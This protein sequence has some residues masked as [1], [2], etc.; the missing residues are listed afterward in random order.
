MSNINVKGIQDYLKQNQ[1]DGWLIF[2]FRGQNYVATNFFKMNKERLL[3]R[4]WFYFIPQVGQPQLVI[5]KIERD[6]FPNPPQQ[7]Q[8]YVSWQ[9]LGNH[10]R[11]MM[12]GCKKIA[13]EYSPNGAIPYVS[14]VDG[15][16]LEFVRALGF[17]IVTSANLV[18]YFQCRWTPEQLQSHIRAV[19]LL[20]QIKD[21]AFALIG[22]RLTNQQTVNEYDVQRFILNSLQ[23]N[24]LLTDELPIVSVNANAS[25]P[26]YAPSSN[27]FSP[28]KE[29]D[30]VLIDLF[31]KE[32]TANAVYGDITWVGFAG[33]GVPEKYSEIFKIVAAARDAGLESLKLA[34]ARGEKI[35]GWQVDRCVRD[36]IKKA[37]YG[38][39]F[40]HRTGHSLHTKI[41]GNGVNID[42]LET[43]DEREIIPGLGF[44]I[45]PGIYLEEFGVRSEVDVYYDEDGPKVYAPI[46]QEVVAILK[47]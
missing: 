13:M 19:K 45:E 11:E 6:N 3:T 7:V 34:A 40:D 20:D 21:E 37:G 33:E 29:N 26:H 41:H 46:Q 32:R 24:D 2:D 44:T 8:Y 25:N 30:F 23:D 27:R 15:G 31:A 14:T 1:I 28:I 43:Q 47:S 10:L 22:R 42:S 4:R 18:Q 39:Y 38:D 36:Y 12:Q 35:Q 9:E 5:H 16:T 17:E